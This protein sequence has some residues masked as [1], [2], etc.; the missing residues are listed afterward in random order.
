MTDEANENSTK[1]LDIAFKDKEGNPS[2]P[3][4]VRYRVDCIT[5]GE[6]IKPETIIT[7]T[8]ADMTITLFKT[9]TRIVDPTNRQELR[10]VSIVAEYAVNDEET[11]EYDFYVKNLEYI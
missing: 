11:Q 6:A 2:A 9:E 4:L 7:S 8:S 10:R 3:I 1:Y 5:T